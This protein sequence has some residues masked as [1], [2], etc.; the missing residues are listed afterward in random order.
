MPSP[1]QSRAKTPSTAFQR[2]KEQIKW[3]DV[4]FEICDARCPTASRHPKSD[5]IFGH[6]TRLMILT[7]EDLADTRAL[8]SWQDKAFALS[9]KTQRG[10]DKLI[11]HALTVTEEKRAALTRKGILPRPMRVC[12]VGMPN[13]GKS[14]LINWLIG[15]KKTAVANRPGVTKGTQWVRVHPQLELLDTPGILPV[16]ALSAD[17][18]LKLSLFNLIPA[19]SYEIE[20][21]ARRGL[22]ILQQT[23]PLL[24]QAY[25]P[26]V[27][28]GLATLEELAKKRNFLTSGGKPDHMRAAGTFLTDLRSGKIGRITLD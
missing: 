13:V 24:I 22:D 23:Y 12:V 2:L 26:G 16:G 5:E 15:I 10:K 25:I 3:V 14:S 21:V 4:V 8:E 19:S 11:R 1:P 27:E 17:A 7:K 20:D 6:K 9:L 28:P 18:V